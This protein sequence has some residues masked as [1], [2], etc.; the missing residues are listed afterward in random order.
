M[1][2][3]VSPWRRA[4]AVHGAAA[5]ALILTRAAPSF[6]ALGPRGELFGWL[7]YA[8]LLT[9]GLPGVTL[10]VWLRRPLRSC[11]VTWG[12]ARRD[13]R[14][15]ALGVIGAVAVAAVVAR[16]PSMAAYYPRYRAVLSAP[17]LWLP[18]TLAFAAY[19]LAWEAMF[20][21]ALLFGA[22]ERPGALALA[23]QT[24]LFAIG[25]LDK[26]PL[27]AW[28]SIPAGA[29]LGLAALRTRSILPG[30]VVHFTL[31]TSLNLFCAYGGP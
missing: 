19:G 5:L 10:I 6:R 7:A 9:A 29:L 17:W 1:S 22:F 28:L 25:H 20:R 8:T 13:A 27:E 24:A 12:L 15:I 14:W 16:A 26:P 21:G 2:A 11:G 30:F 31:S 4:A 3:A 23:L 18:S